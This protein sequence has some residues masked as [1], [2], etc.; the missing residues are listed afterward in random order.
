MVVIS[1]QCVNKQSYD[2]GYHYKRLF[3][4]QLPSQWL[5][6][7]VKVLSLRLQQCLNPFA[8]LSVEGS[9]KTRPF[10]HLANDVFRSR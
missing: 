1:S 4:T 2:F 8:M 5:R 10:R 9:P 3:L 7:M 6:D